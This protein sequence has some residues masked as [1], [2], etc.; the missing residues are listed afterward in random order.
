MR[1]LLL[2]GGKAT[3]LRPLTDRTPKAMTPVLGRPFLEHVLAWLA[4]YDIRDVTLLLGFLPDPIRDY[5]RDGYQFGVRL[6][7]VVEDQPLGSG[8][9]I[10]QLE[11]ELTEPFFALN[12]D[13][14]TDLNLTTMA[15]D[16]QRSGAEASIFL[17]RVDDPSS[18]GVCA[19]DAGGWIERFVE[20]PRREEAPSDLINAGVWLFEP[21]VLAR[22]A[23]AR[24]T[25]VEQDLFPALAQER[26]LHGYASETAYWIDAGTPE[27]YLLLQAALLNGQA[28]G[29]LAIV[30]RPGWPGLM[31]QAAG[32]EPG[33]EGKPPQAGEGTRL[34]GAVV[35]GAGVT[36][37]DSGVLSGPVTIGA[38]GVI[39]DRAQI[40][41][42]V[43]WE[44]CRIGNDVVIRSS[45]L[46]RGC[47]VDE[48]V[49][50]E[51]CVLGDGARV[52]AGA[53]LTEARIDP[54]EI[55]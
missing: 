39:G 6:T 51:R 53:V 45:V 20:K 18:Y 29:A 21:S 43:L 33:G 42:S 22:I 11:R 34:D 30:E 1:A 28:A 48:G 41:G 9:A 47:T 4:R 10:K 19:V 27:R 14:F 5:F 26:R 36:I 38:R 52:H 16:H 55:V 49:V 17:A 24:F 46:A 44:D 50:L 25:M 8:G 35:L 23:A 12:A 2:A 54:G 7:Y 13:I 15:A 3:R 31:L 37:G 32:G 40:A